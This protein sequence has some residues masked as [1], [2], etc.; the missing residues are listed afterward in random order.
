MFTFYSFRNYETTPFKITP[1]I[2]IVILININKTKK[3][4]EY[5]IK[6]VSSSEFKL[7]NKGINIAN[8]KYIPVYLK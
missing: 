7:T 4:F 1:F 5:E 8:T 3:N 6:V 2:S